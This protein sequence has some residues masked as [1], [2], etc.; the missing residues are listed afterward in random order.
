MLYLNQ[1]RLLKS[2]FGFFTG[3]VQIKEA[4]VALRFLEFS[5]N[6]HHSLPGVSSYPQEGAIPADMIRD[7]LYSRQIFAEDDSDIPCNGKFL[8]PVLIPAE[9][10][11]L[12]RVILCLHGLNERDYLK[13]LPWASKFARRTK[14]A[15]I[16]FPVAFHM[17]RAP[18]LWSDT[19][20]MNRL[21]M[22]RQSLFPDL[23]DS[24]F[25]NA[26]ISTRI[27]HCPERFFLSGCQTYYDLLNL[28]GKIRSGSIPF[29]DRNARIDLFGYSIGAMLSE[30]LYLTNKDGIFDDS[31][32]AIFCGGTTIDKAHPQAKTIF[33][34][35]AYEAFFKLLI[36]DFEA[37]EKTHRCMGEYFGQ[38]LHESDMFKSFFNE[39]NLRTIRTE[40]LKNRK[41]GIYAVALN[42]DRVMPPSGIIDTL[43]GKNNEIGIRVDVFDPDYKYT[44]EAPFP[45]SESSKEEVD[46]SFNR[47]FD[48]FSDFFRS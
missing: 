16:L 4:E 23:K 32:L 35:K 14:S 22:E 34:S 11:T 36:K 5:S 29:I 24:S 18:S 7:S 1:Y 6:G 21:S 43:C 45:A 37:S 33:D 38:R 2:S 41:E 15:V 48:G 39:N 10:R 9:T 46:V 13:Y 30:V 17:N 25:A 42:K 20:Q 44:H 31:K 26:A 40:A 47:I 19:R 12:E 3:E 28:S 27:Q 8:C